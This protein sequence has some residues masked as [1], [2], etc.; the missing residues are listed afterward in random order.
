MLT[1]RH[2]SSFTWPMQRLNELL[3]SPV[4]DSVLKGMSTNTISED[5]NAHL[6][7]KDIMPNLGYLS[8]D[9]YCM[10]HDNV[11]EPRLTISRPK[12][13]RTSALKRHPSRG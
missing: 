13:T 2:E 9:S 6:I 10:I 12:G 1:K 11:D 7:D 5:L 3:I 8:N 4:R